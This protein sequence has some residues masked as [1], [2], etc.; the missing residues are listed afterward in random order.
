MTSN[1]DRAAEILAPHAFVTSRAA[2]AQKE[3]TN[4]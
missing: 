4:E 3:E 1:R 2:D